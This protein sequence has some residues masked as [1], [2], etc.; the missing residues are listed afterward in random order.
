M[1]N[2]NATARGTFELGTFFITQHSDSDISFVYSP[3]VIRLP[4][5]SAAKP[6]HSSFR[7]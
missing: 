2:N 6:G 1:T 7:S 4:R 3:F 5:R